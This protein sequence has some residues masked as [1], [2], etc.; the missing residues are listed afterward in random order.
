MKKKK[1][2]G[3]HYIAEY[4]ECNSKI[5]NDADLIQKIMLKASEL[6]GA[7]IIKPIFHRFSP[8]GVSGVVVI[9]ESHFAIHTWP[10]H[11]FAA[12]DLF[13]CSDFDYS[14][15][16]EYVRD[17]I[18]AK[19]FSFSSIDRGVLPETKGEF[20]SIKIKKIV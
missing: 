13:S 6:S 9:A 1:K 20:D 5:I 16:L 8:H 12:V 3:T 2:L 14:K 11:S 4:F 17:K 15:A 7:T 18:R 10:E 19:E